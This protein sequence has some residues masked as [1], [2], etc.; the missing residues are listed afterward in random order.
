MEIAEAVFQ[1]LDDMQRVSEEDQLR[2]EIL[3]LQK[4]LQTE[5]DLRNQAETENFNDFE[6][7]EAFCE[8]LDHQLQKEKKLRQRRANRKLLKSGRYFSKVWRKPERFSAESQML[9][10][11]LKKQEALVGDIVDLIQMLDKEKVLRQRPTN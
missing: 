2:Q 4:A 10:N 6:I 5:K 8:E 11:K 9:A 1:N 3:E 7:E